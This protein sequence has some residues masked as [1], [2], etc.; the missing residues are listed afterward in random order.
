MILTFNC[1]FWMNKC[2]TFFKSCCVENNIFHGCFFVSENHELC[3]L[4]C[5]FFLSLETILWIWKNVLHLFSSSK[6]QVL[7]DIRFTSFK[8]K[9]HW[10]Q[11][12]LTILAN[13]QW[14]IYHEKWFLQFSIWFLSLFII[15]CFI[16]NFNSTNLKTSKEA[17]FFKFYYYS[18]TFFLFISNSAKIINTC[19]FT[20]SLFN[21]HKHLVDGND[22][23][24]QI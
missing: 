7:R 14:M 1:T 18:S 16:F 5:N 13:W 23:L 4:C 6:N 12:L 9:K 10:V 22:I 3:P 19:I 2:K 20:F 15:F 24:I 8:P 17:L 11:K 21:Y